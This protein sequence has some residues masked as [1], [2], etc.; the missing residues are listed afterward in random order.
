MG[1]RSKNKVRTICFFALFNS[2]PQSFKDSPTLKELKIVLWAIWLIRH[3]MMT[4]SFWNFILGDHSTDCLTLGVYFES[5]IDYEGFDLIE[6][7]LTLIH[8]K[9]V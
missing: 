5:P 7:T 3:S 6:I 4:M 8:T 1:R 2:L 9:F